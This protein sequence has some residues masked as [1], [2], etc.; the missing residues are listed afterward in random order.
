M[1][2]RAPDRVKVVLD[3]GS[4]ERRAVLTSAPV[5]AVLMLCYVGILQYAY[6]TQIAPEFTYLQ[7]GYR[8]PDP[9]GVGVAIALAVGLALMMPRRI[10]APSHF[11]VWVLFIIAI[12]PSLV[13]PQWA[14]ALPQREALEMALWVG[15]C[16]AL[17]VGLGT[18]QLL[19]GFVPRHP[20]RSATF[21]Q[22]IA[23]LFIVL[24]AYALRT[25]GVNL[26]LPS[27]DNVYGVRGEFHGLEAQHPQL[28]YAVPL[29]IGVINPAMMARGL[30]DRRPLWFVAGVLGQVYVYAVE[31]DKSALLSPIAI[32]AAF[33]LL[34]RGRRPAGASALVGAAVLAVVAMAV[35]VTSLLVR[36]FLITPGLVA[37]G[38]VQVFDEA[39]K[40]HLGYSVLRGFVQYPYQAEPPDLVGRLFF[41]DPTT[42]ANTGWLGDGF[43]N[44]GYPGMVGA[45]LILVL[46][47]WA[48]DD[49]TKGLPLGFTCLFLLPLALG[50]CEAAILTAIL[51][52]GVLVAIVLCALAP[53]TGWLRS[54]AVVEMAG[55]ASGEHQRAG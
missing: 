15:A 16:S 30:W 31:G 37:A 8:T 38:F 35:G 10:A 23:G 9:L 2:Q 13:V 48:I 25:T 43:A 7:Y 14:P 3:G 47:L 40:A 51:T 12:V 28:G 54:G 6:V 36:R 44:F 55:P 19:R 52:H 5:I 33:L 45:S 27:L 39:P 50:L 24:N 46:L 4:A 17:V 20:L 26:T 18:R 32:V 53:R 1:A 41:G 42:H 29:L 34:W 11:I 49:A 22:I 21:W